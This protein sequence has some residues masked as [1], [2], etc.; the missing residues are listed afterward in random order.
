MKKT[1]VK[2]V[3]CVILSLIIAF[4]CFAVVSI[5]AGSITIVKQPS[6]RSLYQGIDWSYNKAGTITLIKDIDLTGAKLSSGG[7]TVEY[8]AGKFSNMYSKPDSGSWKIGENSVRIYCDGFSGYALTT[9]KII[10]VESISLVTP[11]VNTVFV[12][13]LDWKAGLR[14][15]VEFSELN[16]TGLTIK[17]KYTDGINKTLSYPDNQL[18]GWA[19]SKNTDTIKPGKATI[20]ATFCGKTAPFSV[21]FVNENPFAMGDV[22]KDGVIN[23]YDALLVLQHTTEMI[24]LDYSKVR[25]GDVNKSGGLNSY[26]ALMILQ[27]TVGILKSL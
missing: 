5:S 21:E 18:I 3:F 6:N 11:P 13:G 19:V 25:L 4:S 16:I 14:G 7:K 10:E 24:T 27:Y 20:Y 8:V 15:D 22:S 2:A 1:S 23:S 12:K 26:D 9:I 17:A